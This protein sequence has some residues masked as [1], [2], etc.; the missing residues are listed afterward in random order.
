MATNERHPIVCSAC[1]SDRG[2]SLD[3]AQIEQQTDGIC[4]N[5]GAPGHKRLP[6]A[7]LLAL[8]HRFFVWGSFLRMRYGAAPRVQFNEHQ[9]T[10]LDVGPGL[11]QTSGSLNA[12]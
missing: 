12:F 7:G 8:A 3:A 6:V 4:Q 11:P 1:F 2:I 9:H 10:Y 5:C